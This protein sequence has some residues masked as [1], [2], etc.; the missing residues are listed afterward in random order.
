MN[1][2]KKVILADDQIVNLSVGR[3][4]LSG[5]YEVF[6]VPSG[7]KLLLLLQRIIPD[8]ILLDIEMPGMNGYETIRQI[9]SNPETEHIPVIFLTGRSDVG[10]ELEGL[11][12]GAVDYIYK[13]FSPPLLLK[14]IEVHMH[15]EDLK[16]E[17]QHY[18]EMIKAEKSME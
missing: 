12:L 13:P 6:T 16:K 5:A 11:S 14:R 8:I 15:I 1:V 4:V 7:E 10:S 2:K 18:K 17:N 3:E 9:K